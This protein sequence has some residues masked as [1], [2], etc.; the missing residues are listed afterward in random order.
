[1][2]KAQAYLCIHCGR[3]LSAEGKIVSRVY[4]LL[5]A[6]VARKWT[7]GAAEVVVLQVSCA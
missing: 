7:I 5:T 6:T 4:V 3:R 2:F 1:M